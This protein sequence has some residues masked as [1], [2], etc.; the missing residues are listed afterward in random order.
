MNLISVKLYLEQSIL[1]ATKSED[2]VEK[3]YNELYRP[4]AETLL[5]QVAQLKEQKGLL[6]RDLIN[7]RQVVEGIQRMMVKGAG[8]R[9][10]RELENEDSDASG[11]Y[12]KRARRGNNFAT[13]GKIHG[14]SHLS[15]KAHI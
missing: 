9:K 7:A 13:S 10:S 8:K 4:G 3:I 14:G 15:T 5:E 6:I 2:I 12:V 1:A 11:R